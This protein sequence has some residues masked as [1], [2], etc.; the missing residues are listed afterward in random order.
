MIRITTMPVG[1]RAGLAGRHIV[2]CG[3]PAGKECDALVS[4]NGTLLLSTMGNPACDQLVLDREELQETQW[5]EPMKA[6]L[7]ADKLEEIRGLMM[8]G[9]YLEASK[10]SVRYAEESGT[11]QTVHTAPYHAAMVME[12]T[13]PVEEALEYLWTLDM[14]TSLITIRWEEKGELYKREMFCSRADGIAVM[15]VTAPSGKLNLSLKGSAPEFSGWEK[16]VL[17]TN[18]VPGAEELHY[19]N[20]PVAPSV[21]VSHTQE[22]ILLAGVYF[23]KNHGGY[24]SAVRVVADGGRVCADETGIRI[25][26]AGSAVFLMGARRNH[27]VQPQGDEKALMAE[28]QA[29]EPDFDRLLA[30]HAAIHQPIFDRLSVELGGDPQ[31]YLLTTVELKQKEFLSPHILPAY[32]EAMVD[33]GR[34]FL[35]NECGKFPS[36][37][38]HVNININHQISCGNIGNMPEMM[39][40]FF[41]MM[42]WQLE[43]G[44][45]NA[46]RILGCRGFLIAT[47]FDM[48]SAKLYHFNENWPHHYWISGS[49]W[50]LNPLLEHYFCTGDTD[51]LRDRAIPFY[52]ELGLFYEDFLKVRDQ[53]GK[54]LF[55]PSYSPENFPSNTGV[56]QSINATMDI[57]V[58]RE[59][60][61]TLITYAPMVGAATE[62]E[63]A[64]WK[65]LLDEMAP[66]TF[67]T[68]GE[69]DEWA[70]EGLEDRKDHRH[71]SHLYGA[72]PGD[73]FQPEL[74]PELHKAAM[75]ANRMHAVDNESFHGVGH[76]AQ[77]AA[78]LKDS[79]LVDSLLRFS[80][81]AGYITDSFRTVHNP[82]FTQYMPDAQGG[83]PT[84]LLESLF[85]SRPGF[86]EPLPAL[87]C[88]AFRKGSVKGLVA[89]SFALVDELAWDM[90][91][92]SITLAVTSKVDQEITACY[93]EGFRS[94][95]CEG[96]VYGKGSGDIYRQVW[97][98]A[99]ETAV[100][101]W[102]I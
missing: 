81:D 29:V 61:S 10:L 73:E 28:L 7:I 39:E 32:L 90:D 12:L 59:V 88:G 77:A 3:V 58:A 52:K 60:L 5:D 102:S 49:G 26:N 30:K 1:R 79:W 21:E 78:R 92:G 75:I 100:L 97:L 65:R 82:Y 9:K 84:I 86:M 71:A 57:S 95:A 48:E 94:F 50:C 89:R 8:Q 42:D 20:E 33:M 91:R 13:Q 45:E 99:G 83:I 2:T 76:R 72:Y 35:L 54:L 53:N 41:R 80:L 14:R 93:R 46:Q 67:G 38:G 55:I 23:H 16:P 62:E 64:T 34:F 98:K 11:P 18:F 96:A 101:H 85:Y 25:E 40:S 68:H 63:L 43:D 87:P 51:F 17:G 24:T 44:R 22:G 19:T 31:D 4:G 66:Y 37:C 27:T 69:L 56:M 47:H 70:Y 15:R 74:N 6:P 36:I